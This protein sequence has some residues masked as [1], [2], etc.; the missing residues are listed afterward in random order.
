[1][2]VTIHRPGLGCHLDLEGYK[3]ETYEGDLN[4]ISGC[5]ITF[6]MTSLEKG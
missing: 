2:K 5:Q 6:R 3:K 4:N 1:M